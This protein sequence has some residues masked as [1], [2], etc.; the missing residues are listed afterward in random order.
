MRIIWLPWL[1]LMLFIIPFNVDSFQL[2]GE[3]TVL[4]PNATESSN[5]T[6]S[7]GAQGAQ[8]AINTSRSNIKTA[9]YGF[10]VVTQNETTS[11][12]LT[13]TNTISDT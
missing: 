10:K 3:L 2:R 1:C 4:C 12:D 11:V 13:I 9:R 8:A 6:S 7:E 5:T